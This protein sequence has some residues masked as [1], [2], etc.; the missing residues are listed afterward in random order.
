MGSAC[1]QAQHDYLAGNYPVVREDAAQMCALQMQAECGPAM[2][3]NPDALE[4]AIERF[5]HKQV[6]CQPQHHQQHLSKHFNGINSFTTYTHTLTTW[7]G[8]VHCCFAS[9]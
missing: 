3:D 8:R 5:V 4:T 2:L 6:L 7:R 1:A 9:F